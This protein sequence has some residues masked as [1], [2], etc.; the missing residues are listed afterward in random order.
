MTYEYLDDN[1]R[2]PRWNSQDTEVRLAYRFESVKMLFRKLREINI[3]FTALCCQPEGI[4]LGELAFFCA[5]N[6]N[7]VLYTVGNNR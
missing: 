7:K 3:A 5:F 4:T 1:N 6:T 2:M